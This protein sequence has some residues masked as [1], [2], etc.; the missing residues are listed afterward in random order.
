MTKPEVQSC[1]TE[2]EKG[3]TQLIVKVKESW[4]W[5]V[6]MFIEVPRKT[7]RR[8]FENWARRGVNYIRGRMKASIARKFRSSQRS[9]SFRKFIQHLVARRQASS[10]YSWGMWDFWESELEIEGQQYLEGKTKFKKRLGGE[11]AGEWWFSPA[12]V[13]II[14]RAFKN[15]PRLSTSKPTVSNSLR[16]VLSTL[17]YRNSKLLNG[18]FRWEVA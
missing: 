6:Y 9:V 16:W 18:L 10:P 8:W 11:E 12:Y 17:F 2:G 3:P 4:R 14:P 7:V 1:W 15:H 5:L 13:R